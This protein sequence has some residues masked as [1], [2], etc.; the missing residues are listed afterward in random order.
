MV[1][2]YIHS[3]TREAGPVL[4]RVVEKTGHRD[5]RANNRRL[6]LQSLFRSAGSSRADLA[7]LTG[8]TPATVSDLVAALL[9]EGLAEELGRGPA[10]VGKP[11]TLVGLNVSSRYVISADLSDSSVLRT[12]A[13]DLAGK[14]VHRVERRFRG[15]TGEAAV[16]LTEEA[17]ADVIS[18]APGPL[19]G[20]GVGM[21][22]VVTPTGTVVEADALGWF[23]LHLARR[24]Q[25]RFDLPVS[26]S[27]DAN[28]AALAE[29]SYAME[30]SRNLMAIKIGDGVGAGIIVNGQQYYGESFSAGEIG[31]VV[32]VDDG[33]PCRCGHHGCLETFLSV[34]LLRA[35]I[36]AG[37][38]PDR[39]ASAAGHRLGLALTTAVSVLDIHD[40]VVSASGL[41]RQDR[42][43][44]AALATL[45]ARTL[46]R[47]GKSV[48]M[49]PSDL[50][51]D[52]ILLGANVLVLNQE[53][54]VA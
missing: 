19:L 32:V 50:G 8:L 13:I 24:L 25:N 9:A 26:V 16:A 20:I 39:V 11:S 2:E 47:L 53:L 1:Y 35:A 42:L 15:I 31:H 29:Y 38:D 22:G 3:I 23:D 10:K 21:P 6:V 12:A 49:R 27:N 36:A 18:I 7:R 40:V 54:G 34:P 41:P 17:I 5:T 43:C 45:R 14:I 37:Q 28:A 48:T 44:R 46:T 30:S 52:V 4:L 51:D 33:P